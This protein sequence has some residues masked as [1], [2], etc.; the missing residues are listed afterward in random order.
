MDA[1]GIA[2]VDGFPVNAGG[3]TSEFEFAGDDFPGEISFA[4]EVGNDIDF[5]GVDQVER[6]AHGGFFL[7]KA[8]VDFA[9]N[10]ALTDFAGVIEIGRRRVRVL[11]RAMPDDEQSRIGL[12]RKMHAGA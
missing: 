8:A 2:V 10:A 9:K 3:G 4:D 12:W 6:F 11:C 7:P 5:F 1:N